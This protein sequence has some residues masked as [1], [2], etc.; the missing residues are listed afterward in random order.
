MKFYQMSPAQKQQVVETI[1]N[2]LMPRKEIMFAFIY[3]SFHDL[4]EDNLPF[5]DID[6]GL[7]VAGMAEKAGVYYGFDLSERLSSLVKTP[8]DVRVI[9]FAPLTFQF[10]VVRGQLII[11]NDEDARCAFTEHVVRHYLDMEPLY[12]RAIKEAFGS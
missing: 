7:Y 12:I 6:V 8:V 2:A 3:G 5:R 4:D 1:I 11:D 9:N 10:H